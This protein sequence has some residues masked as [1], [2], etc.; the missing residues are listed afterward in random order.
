MR[1]NT[2]EPGR[3]QMTIW[4]MHITGRIPKA[5]DTHSEF[6]ITIAFRLQQWLHESAS[7]LLTLPVFVLLAASQPPNLFTFRLPY[8]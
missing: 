7:V 3:P 4:R 1:T 2:V 5:T 8:T 6:L